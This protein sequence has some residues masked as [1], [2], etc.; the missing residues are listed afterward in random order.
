[1][2]E[3]RSPGSSESAFVTL[4]YQDSSL[5]MKFS[6]FDSAL[7]PTLDPLDV[8]LFLKR[9]RKKFEPL[10]LRYYL[11]GEYGDE[12]FRPHYH[13]ALWGLPPEILAGPDG[14]GEP[15]LSLWGKGHVFAG[16]L[17]FESA[18]YIAGYV[19]KKMTSE[20]DPR[21]EGREPEFARMSRGIGKGF[22]PLMAKALENHDDTWYTRY[23]DAPAVVRINNRI[24]PLGRYL[25]GRLRL[26]LGFPEAVDK[27]G[28]PLGYAKA[29]KDKP[30]PWVS[31]AAF[32]A[33][34]DKAQ[35]QQECA[36]LEAKFKA[37]KRRGVI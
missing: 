25:V 10:R 6:S 22:V 18:A 29:P 12:T 28:K 4:T 15:L 26:D 14:T 9:L 11:A 23:H 31:T 30:L 27:D 2:L 1:M 8:Q 33:A 24:R 34:A 20:D 32:V 19:T 36:N 16:D 5:P 3:S 13:L 21:L 7:L 37:T 35:R 17:T